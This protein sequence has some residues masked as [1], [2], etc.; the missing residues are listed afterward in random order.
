LLIRE[1]VLEEEKKQY[2]SQ[3]NKLK[4]YIKAALNY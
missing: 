4:Q 2:V 3:I 1:N